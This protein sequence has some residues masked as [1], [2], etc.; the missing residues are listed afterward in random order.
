MS[1]ER[2]SYWQE[3]ARQCRDYARTQDEPVATRLCELARR[4]ERLADPAT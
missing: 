4:Y 2:R 1:T 3:R